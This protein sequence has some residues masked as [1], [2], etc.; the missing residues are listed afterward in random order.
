MNMYVEEIPPDECRRILQGSYLGRVACSRNDHPYVVPFYFAYDGGDCLFAF[1]TVGRKIRWMRANP[2]VCVEVDDV[3]GHDDWQTLIIFGQF[4]ELPDE[5]K[6]E[7]VRQHAHELLSKRPMWWKPAY[8]AGI[9]GEDPNED[10]V[11]FRIR[12]DS[13]TGHRS[14]GEQTESH[15][16]PVR[17]DRGTRS[18]LRNLRL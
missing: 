12:I 7:S 15:A 2:N 6:Y 4:E 10:P 1:S 14:S 9:H 3:R 13:I 18:W 11:Y 17:A 5:P 8:V 16:P